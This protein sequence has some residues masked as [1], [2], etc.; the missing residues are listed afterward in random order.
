MSYNGKIVK[1]CFPDLAIMKRKSNEALFKGRNLPSFVRDFIL[2]RCADKNG[3]VDGELVRQY[4]DTKMPADG[5]SIKQRLIGGD[6]INMTTR[7]IVNTDIA[8]GI[9]HFAM[10]DIGIVSDAL[11][12][13]ELLENKE[14]PLTDGEHWGNVTLVYVE[15]QARRKGFVLMTTY[16]SFNPYRIDMSY[17]MR[18]RE[19]FTT[20]EWVDFLVAT[21]EY[22]P[23]KF[24][25]E[26]K[27]ELISRLLVLVE[28]RLNI[29]ELGPKG[30]GKSYVF[31]NL[32]KYAWLLA[33][34]RTSR[35]KMFYNKSTKK[36]GVMKDY[37]VVGIDEITSFQF[38][39]PD[40]MQ[41]IMKSYLE[42]GKAAVDD[43]MFQSECGLMLM[44]NIPLDENMKPLDR[45]YVKKLPEMFRE[46]ATM[47]RFHGFIEGWK[48][49]RLTNEHLMEGWV[50]NSEYFS[51]V[52]H[53]LRTASEYDAVFAELVQMP[54]GCDLRDKKAVQRVTTAYHK[55]LFPHIHSLADIEL[56]QVE[57][58][59]DLYDR[60]CLQPAVKRRQIIRSQCHLIDKEFKSE[61]Q[62]F[63]VN[64]KN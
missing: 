54:S 60:W 52:L 1:E 40:E 9:V 41:S 10:P 22:N 13:S 49:P 63:K 61:M 35:A 29:I 28:P 64:L 58:F 48:I 37:D 26:Q 12:S 45:S 32:S 8:Q 31:N 25:L 33:G 14:D 53:I 30:T 15:P 4:L 18:A 2:R 27:L 36:F 21:M 24:N 39:D 34:G 17:Y 47:D 23:E 16:K 19:K 3:N 44:G 11:V 59:K 38:S 20:E 6:S 50:L 56:D 43:V 55:L 51:S 62:E 57:M 42:A 46:S 7:F 5:E